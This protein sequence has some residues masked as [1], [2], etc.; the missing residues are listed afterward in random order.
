M[1]QHEAKRKIGMVTRE[2]LVAEDGLSFMRGLIDGRHP[3]PPFAEFLD[4]DLM[5]IDYGSAVFVGKPTERF[6]NPIGSIQ[7]GW[8]ATILDA[9]MGFATHSTLKVGESYTTLEMKL[10]YVRPLLPSSG[11][12]RCVGKVIHRGG[13]VATAEAQLLDGNGKLLSHSTE[14]C[15]IFPAEPTL[16]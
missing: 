3:Y 7:G 12:V 10:N 13:R 16:K 11:K 1:T 8:A 4:I 5:E 2:E 6:F 9:A 15:M 14:T